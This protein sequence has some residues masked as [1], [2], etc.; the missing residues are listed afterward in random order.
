MTAL[1]YEHCQLLPTCFHA[2]AVAI[3]AFAVL[4]CALYPQHRSVHLLMQ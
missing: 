3:D 1:L 4:T 2:A